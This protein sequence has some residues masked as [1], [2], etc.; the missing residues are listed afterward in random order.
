M[1]TYVV[2]KGASKPSVNDQKTIKEDSGTKAGA[3]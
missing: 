2:N 1:T 3:E